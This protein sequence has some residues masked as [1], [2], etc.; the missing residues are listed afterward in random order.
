MNTSLA[1]KRN[2]CIIG[3]MAMLI[4]LCASAL[5]TTKG[6]NQIV[7]PDIQPEGVLSVGLQ[8]QNNAIGN[9]KELQL[10]LGLT[11]NFEIAV[12]RG[13]SPGETVLNAELGIIK[14]KSFLLSTGVLGVENGLKPQPFLECGY[15]IGK[16]FIIA[17][18][19]RQSPGSVAIL[20]ASY[21]CTPKIL[22]TADYLGGSNNFSTVGVTYTLSP[23]MTFN[24]AVYISNSSPRNYYGYAVV[25]WN[26]KLW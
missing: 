26:T 1:L 17:G 4:G 18:V 15:Y 5:A 9:G 25:S 12:F 13:F 7:T 21:Q 16:G 20:G 11:Q 8:A 22:L 2:C 23:T 10:E 24:P 19:Q 14:T 6:L 3:T